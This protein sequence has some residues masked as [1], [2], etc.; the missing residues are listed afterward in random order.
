M[1]SLTITSSNNKHKYISVPAETTGAPE[2][3]GG[4]WGVS[5]LPT[6]GGGSLASTPAPALL[7]V[8]KG[9]LAAPLEGSL[10]SVPAT[11]RGAVPSGRHKGGA[12]PSWDPAIFRTGKRGY[13]AIA[14]F[15]FSGEKYRIQPA[16]KPLTGFSKP[17][18]GSWVRKLKSGEEVQDLFHNCGVLGCPKCGPV[19][20][21][22]KAR[23]AEKRFEQYERAKL[24]ENAV[25]IPGERRKVLPR[26]IPFTISPTHTAEL[27]MKAGKDH[28]AFL[29]LARAEYNEILKACGMIGGISP[30]H[31]SRVQHPDTGHTGTRA[32]HLIKMEAKLAGNMK[33]D[34]PASDLYIH[35]NRQKN[36]K[37][38]YRFAPHFHFVGFGALPSSKEFEERFPGWRY[39]NKGDVY[40]VGGL[41]RYLFTHQAMIA[42]RQSVT[43]TGRLSRAV[44]GVEELSTTEREVICEKTQLPWVIVESM[45]PEEIGRTW[46]E[47]FTEY[48]SFFRTGMKRAKRA[49]G[50][51]V[52]PK[53]GKRSMAPPEVHEKG[54]LAMAEYCDEFGRM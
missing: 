51:L 27:W 47:S 6:Q 16:S 2:Q 9:G 28:A 23:E 1:E 32:K 35:I 7:P 22:Q 21:T 8:P 17:D 24:Q 26:H 33:D 31:D 52:F 10:T 29:D 5:P 19:A 39:H 30:Y 41:L 12:S 46:M 36:W 15:N 49:P 54:I 11:P 25:L 50:A 37:D 53:S 18:C 14:G 40:N 48:R 34:S 20:I 38:Y 13:P 45:I 3:T 4:G 44:L 42:D 43:W